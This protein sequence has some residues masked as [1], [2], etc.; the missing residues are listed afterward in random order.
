MDKYQK[1]LVDYIK[2]AADTSIP[3]V[4]CREKA[5][6]VKINKDTLK[7]IKEKRK[8]RRQYAKQKLPSAK[9]SINTLQK[10]INQELNKETTTRWGKFCNSV[11]LEKNPAK[12]RCRIKNFL[13]PKTQKTYPTLT[14]DNKT[15]KTNADKAELS[16]ESMGRHFGTECNNF[17][18]AN[19]REID[20]LVETNPYIFTPLDSTNDGIHEKDDNHPLVADVDPKELINIVKFEL[21]KGKA[22]GRDT[23]THE[24]LRLATGAPFYTHLAKF[25]TFSL[26]IGYIPTVWKLA[27]LS[28]LIKPDRLPSITASYRPIKLT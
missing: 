7:L 16:A 5:G 13:K 27:T 17:N 1:R 3:K 25:F 21:K 4:D 14:P 28:M 8:L 12:S 18:D 20:Q 15:A 26:R 22:P 6:E 24:L 2:K 9:S 11:S 10:E 23:I 19:L